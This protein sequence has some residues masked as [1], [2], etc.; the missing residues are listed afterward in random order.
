HTT[1]TPIPWTTQNLLAAVEYAAKKLFFSIDRAN[2]NRRSITE[3]LDDKIMGEVA[4]VAVVEYLRSVSLQAASYDQ[5]RLDSF[6]RPDP[7]W[8]ILLGDGAYRWI[9]AADRSDGRPASVKTASVKSSRLP[10]G[11]DLKKAIANRDFK[12]FARSNQTLTDALT[13]DTEMQ[14]YFERNGSWLP[15]GAQISADE[16]TACTLARANCQIVLDKLQVKARFG[17]CYLTAWNWRENIVQDSAKLRPPTW[18]SYHAGHT[19]Q[20]W[21]APLKNGRGFAQIQKDLA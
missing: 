2:M 6:K 7:G 14:V 11:D 10:K 20:M 21:R 17:T 19:K 5:F 12:I 3:S 13:A 16:V 4:T 9:E 8:D 18:R 15:K 1:I